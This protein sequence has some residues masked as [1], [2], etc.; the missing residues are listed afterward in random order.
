M[1]TLRI[2]NIV[3]CHIPIIGVDVYGLINYKWGGQFFIMM[4]ETLL[5]TLSMIGMTIW[6][7]KA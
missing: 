6:E 1:N 3:L 5:L 7:L 2:V 4:I